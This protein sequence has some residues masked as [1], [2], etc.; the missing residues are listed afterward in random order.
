VAS[1]G[2]EA[3]LAGPATA[4][5]AAFDFGPRRRLLDIGG[6]TG[7]WSIAVVQRHQHLTGAVLELPTAADLARSR[8]AA[9]GSGT[10]S[11]CSPATPWRWSAPDGASLV[12]ARSSGRRA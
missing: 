3:I 7:S 1:A 10:G 11:P 12:T 4:L 5:P 8:V 2:I 9:A 6:G